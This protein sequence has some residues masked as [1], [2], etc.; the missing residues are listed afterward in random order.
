MSHPVATAE[1]HAI[2]V[3]VA[4]D[5]L[6]HQ[7]FSARIE[8]GFDVFLALVLFLELILMFGNT[9]MRGMF[10][11]SFV[12]ANEVAEYALTSLAFIG[13]AVAYHRG[14]HLVVR[15]GI[16]KLPERFR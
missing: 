3:E 4:A 10:N 5:N 15:F 9:A 7:R 13:G 8:H 16:D 2:G 12:W 11:T 14:L 1:H 6:P